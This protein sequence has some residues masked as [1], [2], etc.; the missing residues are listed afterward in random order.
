[1]PDASTTDAPAR[2]RRRHLRVLVALVA[3]LGLGSAGFGTTY[4]YLRDSSTVQGATITSGSLDLWLYA[5][6]TSSTSLG[7]NLAHVRG[8]TRSHNVPV[9]TTAGTSTAVDATIVST[10]GALAQHVTL[11]TRIG[12]QT[13]CPETGTPDASG[14][15]TSFGTQRVIA[16]TTTGTTYLCVYLTVRADTPVNLV[17]QTAGFDLRFDAVTAR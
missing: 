9:L 8:I 6:G 13:Q 16:P 10:S 17:G 4:A 2:P 12:T 7:T 1:M 11:E 14:P 15:L 3:A 5:K